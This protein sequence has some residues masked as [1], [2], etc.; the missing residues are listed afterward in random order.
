MRAE[1]SCHEDIYYFF[2]SKQEGNGP[3]DPDIAPELYDPDNALAVYNNAMDAIATCGNPDEA[4]VS[5]LSLHS[6]VGRLLASA[7]FS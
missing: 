6:N 5:D 4:A 1:D 2:E 7:C 3:I